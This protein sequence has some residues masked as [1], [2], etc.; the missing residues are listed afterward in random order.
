MFAKTS[1]LCRSLKRFGISANLCV[2]VH[3][4]VSVLLAEFQNICSL[5]LQIMFKY[6]GPGDLNIDGIVVLRVFRYFS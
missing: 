2:H 4:H 1:T 6:R 5:G 3:Q